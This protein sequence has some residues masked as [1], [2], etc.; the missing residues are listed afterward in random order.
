MK[1]NAKKGHV[2]L[3][4]SNELTVKIN[5]VQIKN[6]QS[7]KLL[8]ITI[9][10]VLKLEDRINNI[11]R[12]ASAKVSALSRVAPY[13]DLPKRKQI[14]TAFF[15]S[16]FSY[17]PLTWMMHSGKLNNKINQLHER[18]LRVTYNDSLFS[19]EELLERDN[20]VSVQNKNIQCLA[21]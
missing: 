5:V 7:E 1:T 15:K 2:L 13:M 4:T 11:C 3:S 19:F 10:N 21:I 12:K 6:S 14:M 8:G 16:Q 18:C 17:I 9:D 20:S